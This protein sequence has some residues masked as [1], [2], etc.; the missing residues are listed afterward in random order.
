MVTCQSTSILWIATGCQTL[1]LQGL[2]EKYTTGSRDRGGRVGILSSVFLDSSLTDGLHSASV[3]SMQMAPDLRHQAQA[4]DLSSRDDSNP[5]LDVSAIVYSDA[6][7]TFGTSKAKF[8]CRPRFPSTPP[9]TCSFSKFS[10]FPPTTIFYSLLPMLTVLQDKSDLPF[11]G[12][13]GP[14]RDLTRLYFLTPPPLSLRSRS[15]ATRSLP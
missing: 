2:K 6:L 14:Q 15:K 3:L 5:C 7:P 13:H 12:C 9:Q 4:F 1:Q 10:T 11:S 8:I